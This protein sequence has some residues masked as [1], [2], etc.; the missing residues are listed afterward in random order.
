MLRIRRKVRSLAQP[1]QLAPAPSRLSITDLAQDIAGD[2]PR[3][4]VLEWSASDRTPAI[5][6]RLLAPFL[7]RGTIVATDSAGLSSLTQ[8]LPLAAVLKLV[9]EPKEI[10]FALG[11]AI[12]GEA[13]GVWTADNSQLF[14]DEAIEP[15]AVLD[16]L[17][18]AQRRIA[19]RTVH[20]G[21]CYRLAGGL[22]GEQ[23]DSIE[24]VAEELT[25][26]GEI[27]S[28]ESTYARMAPRHRAL[29]ALCAP[30][31]A[32]IPLYVTT[33]FGACAFVETP[34]AGADYPAPFSKR[35]LDTLRSHTVAE[36]A[37]MPFAE[38]RRQRAVV[39]VQAAPG[40]RLRLLD[41]F[42]ELAV[43][44]A[45]IRRTVERLGGDLVKSNGAIAI[46]LFERDADAVQ[47]ALALEEELSANA[48]DARIAV[49]R[50]EVFV[51]DLDRADASAPA[52]EIAGDPVN[53]ASKLAEDSALTGIL[54]DRSVSLP[55]LAS[56]YATERF[57]L[58]LG[59]I[60]LDGV[61]VAL[62]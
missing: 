23:A 62:R 44:D 49:A 16:Q 55:P 12:G 53:I 34:D 42:T 54:V 5:H 11:R 17:F 41:A 47:F 21:E 28:T 20:V 10:L 3:D 52:R 13:I 36:L 33:Q 51:F 26:G 6:Q 59:A 32:A 56:R 15:A 27:L 19:S 2:L 45:L 7:V 58:R 38:H 25:R 30:A 1:P 24:H 37:A 50:G 35:F 39:F 46:A 4:L 61:R 9:S 31:R 29:T 40:A 22:F 14:F 57:S 48:P 60:A 18:E 43:V 8:R